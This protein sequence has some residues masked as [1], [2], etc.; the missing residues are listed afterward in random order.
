MKKP[1]ERFK[2]YHKILQTDPFGHKKVI[3]AGLNAAINSVQ[4][5]ALMRDKLSVDSKYNLRILG[6][7]LD[8]P[9][10]SYDK[11]IVVGAGKA[12]GAM[13]ETLETLLP[14]KIQYS[15]VVIVPE[16]TSRYYLTKKIG[17]LEGSHPIPSTK[18]VVAT[19]AVVKVVQSTTEKSLVLCLISG[20]GSALMSLPAKGI[21]LSEKIRTTTLLLKSGAGIE[22]VNT[23]RKHLSAVKGG[24]LALKADGS[25]VVSLILSDIVGNPIGSIASGPTAP[26][27]TTFKD[28]LGILQ[29]YHITQKVPTRVVG[30]LKAG[31]MGQIPETPKPEDPIFQKVNNCILG[32]NSVACFA[33]IEEMKKMISVNPC[34]LGSA[35]QGEARDTAANLV[36]LF[37]TAREDPCNVSGRGYPKA[38]VWGGETTVTVRGKGRGGRNQEEALSSLLRLGNEKGITI[39][40]LGTDGVDGFSLAAGAIIDSASCDRAAMKELFPDKYLMDN[41]STTFFEKLGDSLLLTGP[42][43]TNVNDIG[44]A[45]VLPRLKRT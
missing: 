32:D 39:A 3:L 35:W 18:N 41:D 22:K 45:I 30:R 8:L 20:G 16:G 34:Y 29:E 28:A 42:T 15:G 27:P 1:E 33:A 2:D 10:A 31:A 40:Y 7:N 38:F 13:A 21:S 26:D 4:P 17:I 12:S 25:K 11:L 37:L 24:Q 6:S 36:G 23:V 19:K 44:I 43:S 14:E 5:A 9:L